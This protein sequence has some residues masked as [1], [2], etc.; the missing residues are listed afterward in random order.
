V[1]STGSAE[2]VWAGAPSDRDVTGAEGAADVPETEGSWP[3]VGSAGVVEA[4]V[5]VPRSYC[6]YNR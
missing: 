5:I 4:S 2:V 1:T 3:A 6:V